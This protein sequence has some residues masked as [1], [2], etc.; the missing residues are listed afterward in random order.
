MIICSADLA[1]LS[2]LILCSQ[3][4]VARPWGREPWKICHCF[5]VH[6]QCN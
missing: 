6:L 2:F 5:W 3:G 4:R 1:E